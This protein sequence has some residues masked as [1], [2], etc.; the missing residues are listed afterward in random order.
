MENTV[1]KQAQGMVLDDAALNPV[2]EMAEPLSPISEITEQQPQG[3]QNPQ[4]EQP[5]QKEPGWIK[6]RINKA[7]QQQ[8]TRLRA[9]FE[10][11]LAPIRES[12]Y[13]READ[14]LVA[15]GEFKTKER[16]LEYVKLKAGVSVSAAP[17][18]D[19]QPLQRDAQGR[20]AP[21]QQ[22]QQADPVVKARAD[23][24]AAQAEKIKNSRGVDVIQAFNGDPDIQ[25]K[26]L[27]GEWDFY[28]V[29][30]AV[31]QGGQRRP[32]APMRSPNGASSGGFDIS[33]MSDEQFQKL[34]EN[35]AAGKIYDA[36]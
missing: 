33:K 20:F 1:E 28:D 8:E 36:R 34:Q 4:A 22:E 2:Q 3:Q 26:I 32:L 12:M 11:T 6:Q 5:P 10:A 18:Q 35:L 24:L 21:Q 25:Q 15:A 14:T 7:L 27:S 29:A 31:A 30:E 13:E 16:A 9:E 19:K 17:A 23:L